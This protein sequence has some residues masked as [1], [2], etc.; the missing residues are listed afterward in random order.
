MHIPTFWKRPRVGGAVTAADDKSSRTTRR[1]ARLALLSAAVLLVAMI[2]SANGADGGIGS[3]AIEIDANLYPSPATGCTDYAFNATPLTG[4]D[5]VK[6]CAENLDLTVGTDAAA[7]KGHWNGFRV[8]DGIAGADKDIFLTGGKENDLSTWNPGPGTV[9]SSKYDITQAYLANNN[10]DA[11]FGMERRGNNGTTAFDWEFNRLAPST[12]NP[13]YIPTRSECDVLVTFEMQGSG[14]TGSATPFVFRYDDPDVANTGAQGALNCTGSGNASG[15]TD[16]DGKYVAQSASGVATAI[17]ESPIHS[18]PWGTVD[19]G[20][21]WTTNDIDTFQFAEAK[22]PLSALGINPG[23]TCTNIS[24]YV[25]VRTRSS[26]TDTSD[27]KDLTKIFNFQFF[28][29]VNPTQTV[30]TNCDAQFHFGSSL[31]S[32]TTPT[33]TFTVPLDSNGQS[34]VTLQGLNGTNL[35]GPVD[36]N[37]VRKWTASAFSGDVQVAGFPQGEDSV[38]ID[39][40]QGVQDANGCNTSS[41][42]TITVY[43][44]QTGQ[45]SASADCDGKIT[46]TASVSGGKAPYDITVELQQKQ[47]DGTWVTKHTDTYT[48]DADGSVTNSDTPFDGS[49]DPGTWRAHVTST[50][51][52]S[53][54]PNGGG[55]VITF[56]SD[57]F[58]V[59]APL[60][61]TASKDASTTVGS[62]LTAGLDGG[63]GGA[64]SGDTLA[65]QWQIS[66]DGGTTWDDL[67]G[68]T[69]EDITYDG[70]K[71]DATPSTL[72]FA[73]G[74]GDAQGEY[75]GRLWAVKLRLHA[76]RTIGTQVCS[77]NSSPVPLKVV[78]GVDP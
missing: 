67:A 4:F 15:D 23:D 10:N 34:P 26:S 31:S 3:H 45:A 32:G 78:E 14:K 36:Q 76:T 18:A 11:F 33:W 49:G 21:S 43:R 46:Y 5:W 39:V 2:P 77:A 28:A 19:S 47:S 27:L 16:Q 50:D 65:Y 40:S 63:S 56:N 48:A 69:T 70:F 30:T 51:S 58:E 55:C 35:S 74:T 75:K 20:G 41:S 25:Q 61:A 73:V 13:D 9:G 68:K 17:N 64:L 62:T 54:G 7:Q 44:T 57:T 60:T 12:S 71:T 72:S 22:V 66:T 37:G 1:A 53:V 24:R 59:R 29:P 42:G 8:L 6:D 52:Q 38:K